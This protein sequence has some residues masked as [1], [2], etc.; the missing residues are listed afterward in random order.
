MLNQSYY[1]AHL[2]IKNMNDVNKIIKKYTKG[3]SKFNLGNKETLTWVGIGV[4]GAIALYFILT[5]QSA[6]VKVFDQFNEGVGSAGPYPLSGR[7]SGK[8]PTLPGAGGEPITEGAVKESAFTDWYQ[9]TESK[10]DRL[11]VA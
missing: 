8:L 9:T 5:K 10:D 3:K 7:L 1:M 2:K 4:V 11:I 6:G